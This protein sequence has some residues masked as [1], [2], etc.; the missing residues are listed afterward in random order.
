MLNSFDF[1]YSF[2]TFVLADEATTWTEK[3]VVQYS[4]GSKTVTILWTNLNNKRIVVEAAYPTK[5]LGSVDSLA[6]IVNAQT[7][8]D[9]IA[10]AGI[11]GT[12]FDAYDDFDVSGS[13]IEEGVVRHIVDNYMN[14]I[15]KLIIT[16]NATINPKK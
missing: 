14:R 1:P 5:G 7:N 3:K 4:V 9:G 13:I 12:Y 11:N 10:I 8:S 15:D 2:T 6:N 16:T